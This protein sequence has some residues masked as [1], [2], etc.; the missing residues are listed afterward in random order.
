MSEDDNITRE[1]FKVATDEELVW[2]ADEAMERMRARR[3]WACMACGTIMDF[4]Y[5]EGDFNKLG[6]IDPECRCPDAIEVK[7]AKSYE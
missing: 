2:A 3:K 1:S 4:E 5:I 7:E 6:C